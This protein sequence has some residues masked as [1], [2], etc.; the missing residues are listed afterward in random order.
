MEEQS[1][2]ESMHDQAQVGFTEWS[3]TLRLNTRDQK[4]LGKMVN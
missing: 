2:I 4:K 3:G 1:K